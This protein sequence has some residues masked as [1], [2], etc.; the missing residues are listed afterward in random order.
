MCMNLR[1][2]DSGASF[3]LLSTERIIGCMGKITHKHIAEKA[4]VTESTVSRALSGKASIRNKISQEQREAI[5]EIARDMGYPLDRGRPKDPLPYSVG[6]IVTSIAD[7]FWA[8][9]VEGAEH[10]A[11][12]VGWN[13]VLTFSHND[14]YIERRALHNLFVKQ[15]V[16]GAIIAG[17]R[18][19]LKR[20]N[21]L[22]V[23]GIYRWL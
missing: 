22:A 2:G 23:Q 3:L 10:V 15:K 17:S 5:L 18:G 19:T 7:M 16:A 9:V 11:A 21:S 20:F 4:G 14:P 12:A 1:P 13:M 6:V 8:R